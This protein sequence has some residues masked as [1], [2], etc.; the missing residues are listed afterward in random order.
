MVREGAAGTPRDGGS[1]LVSPLS[2]ELFISGHTKSATIPPT[3]THN[4]NA[5]AIIV[6]VIVDRTGLKFGLRVRR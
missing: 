6:I 3:T 1:A 5:T 2:G 4:R